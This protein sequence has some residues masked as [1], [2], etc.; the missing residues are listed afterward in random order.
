MKKLFAKRGLKKLVLLLQEPLAK[1]HQTSPRPRPGRSD[2]A[3]RVPS[4]GATPCA[5]VFLPPR[6]LRVVFLHCC[7]AGEKHFPAP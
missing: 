6:P 7:D 2:S 1:D 4:A 5:G 3:Q